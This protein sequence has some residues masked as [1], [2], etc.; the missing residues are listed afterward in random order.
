MGKT[1]GWLATLDVFMWS[2]GPI[3]QNCSAVFA[4]DLLELGPSGW[5]FSMGAHALWHW[6]SRKYSRSAIDG[7]SEKEKGKKKG[8]EV[9]SV[10]QR[11]P[12]VNTSTSTPLIKTSRS[13]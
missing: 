2:L 11:F 12:Q 9:V 10:R 8:K 6:N 7:L 4:R 1:S 3:K 5:S 13:S